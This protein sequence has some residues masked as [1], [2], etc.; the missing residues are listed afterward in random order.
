MKKS[1]KYIFGFFIGLI[2][3]LLGACGG[4]LTVAALK[5]DGMEPKKAHANAVAVIVPITI[6]SSIFYI[7]S[8]YVSLDQ[9]LS[10]IPGGVLGAI[11]GGLL[12]PKIPQKALRKVFAV[13]V[14][15]A[16]IR[17]IAR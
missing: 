1:T 7:C 17:M 5:K 10:F 14:I 11:S 9:S 6:I 15:W 2:N 3:S 12:L 8:G 13:I 4:I 16:G